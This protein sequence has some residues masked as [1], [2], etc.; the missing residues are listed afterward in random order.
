[1]NRT[2]TVG[3]LRTLTDW[4]VEV[5]EDALRMLAELGSKSKRSAASAILDQNMI[6]NMLW[7]TT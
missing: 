1:M 6:E 5:I 3:N 2:V 7:A 4:E